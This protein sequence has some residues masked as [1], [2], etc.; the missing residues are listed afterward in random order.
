MRL[1]RYRKRNGTHLGLVWDSKVLSLTDIGKGDP[2]RYG[3]LANAVDLV[4]LLSG[5][6]RT[7]LEKIDRQIKDGGLAGEWAAFSDPEKDVEWLPPVTS[8]EKIICIGLNYSDHAAESK[9]EIPKEPVI[10]NK[11]NN[12]LIG[13]GGP[14]LLPSNSLQVDYEAELAVVIGANAKRVSRE[15]SSRY[16]AGYTLMHDVSAR[17]WQFRTGQWMTGKTFDTFGPCGPHLVTPD[18]V[19]DP[20]NLDIRLTL[21]GQVMQNS[22]TSKLIFDIPTLISYLSHIFTLKAGDIISTG[23]PPG[24]GFARRPQVFLKDGD[25]V[26]IFVEKVGLMQHRCAAEQ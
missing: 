13:A 26:E 6:G 21:N 9:M 23:T 10:F 22:N 3:A 4:P 25:F 11:F 15:E 1:A 20:H 18:E 2:G 8:P 7:T 5:Q 17:D 24:V 14:V 19:P 12:A 16:V